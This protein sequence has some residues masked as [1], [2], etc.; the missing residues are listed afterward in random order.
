MKHS[1]PTDSAM[2]TEMVASTDASFSYQPFDWHRIVSTPV[3]RKVEMVRCSHC[4]SKMPDD[5]SNCSQCGAPLPLQEVEKYQEP[6]TVLVQ[7]HEESD[8]PWWMFWKKG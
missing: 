1:Y 8:H 6:T 2:Y 7:S 4:H 5:I 3:Q